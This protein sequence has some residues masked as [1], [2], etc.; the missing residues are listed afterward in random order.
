MAHTPGGYSS[1]SLQPALRGRFPIGRGPPGNTR[2]ADRRQNTPQCMSACA[3]PRGKL[4]SASAAPTVNRQCVIS[5]LIVRGNL[6]CRAA[7]LDVER[8]PATHRLDQFG[9]RDV[10][11]VNARGRER[12]VPSCAVS[13]AAVASCASSAACVWHPSCPRSRR[14]RRNVAR[15]R[16]RNLPSCIESTTKTRRPSSKAPHTFGA[17]RCSRR[18]PAARG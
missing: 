11:Q 3:P 1:R 17:W 7:P 13:R 10:L 18:P 6:E 12:A 9:R 2:D 5:R 14:R 4:K 15:P 8:W 16:R